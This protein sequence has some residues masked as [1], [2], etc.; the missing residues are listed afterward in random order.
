M[1]TKPRPRTAAAARAT[2]AN[3]SP[4]IDAAVDGR[5]AW[6]DRNLNAV[7]DALL[8][9]FSE[10]NLRPGADEIAARSGVSRRSVFRYFDDLDTLDRAAIARQQ[11]RVTHLVDLPDLGHGSF[12]ERVECLTQQRVRLFQAITPVARVARLREPFEPV[13]AEDL[14]RN[15]RFFKQQIEKQF[16]AELQALDRGQRS[17]TLSAA[18]VL[19]SFESYHLLTGA[20]GL[21]PKQAGDAMNRGL[22]ALLAPSG[23][24]RNK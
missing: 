20:Q 23:A 15:R 13:V 2:D 19:C 3:T 9:L 22:T 12:A 16:A 24:S 1:N 10:G 17:A 7:V 11:A 4:S 8:D 14:R 6:R 18:D 21:T 5:R